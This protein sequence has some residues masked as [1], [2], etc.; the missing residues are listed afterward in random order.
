MKKNKWVK[1]DRGNCT[2]EG[3]GL[4]F[5]I[6]YNP[7]TSKSYEGA[8]GEFIKGMC[9]MV[10]S[11]VGKERKEGKETALRMKRGKWL[12]LEGDFRKEYEVAFPNYKKC[13]AVYKKNI[14]YR[15][16][17]WSTDY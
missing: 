16:E 11:F 3:K 5:Y 8:E 10:F 2:L 14:A 15:S 6:S 9:D 4:G 1:Q 12:V 17:V 13:L 7:D